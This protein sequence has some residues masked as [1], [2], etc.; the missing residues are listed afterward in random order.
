MGEDYKFDNFNNFLDHLAP[1]AQ[2]FEDSQTG[3]NPER[4]NIQDL[5][6]DEIKQSQSSIAE[7]LY[8]ESSSILFEDISDSEDSHN[9]Q[10][11]TNLL[12]PSD[13]VT[14]THTAS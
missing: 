9:I 11:E 12:K 2:D 14:H 3:T 8:E 13:E 6:E 5:P 4:D 1:S 10:M 7:Q